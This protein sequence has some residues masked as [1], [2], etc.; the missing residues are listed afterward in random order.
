MLAVPEIQEYKKCLRSIGEDSRD[1]RPGLGLACRSED[2]SKEA[3]Y[4]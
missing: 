4:P 2:Q 3:S 1:G